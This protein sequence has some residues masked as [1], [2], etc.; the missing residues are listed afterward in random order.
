MKKILTVMTPTY[1]RGDKLKQLYGSLLSQKSNNFKW[2]IVDDG[3]VDETQKIVQGFI[4]DQNKK[5]DISYFYTTNGGKHRAVNFILPKIDTDLL[6]VVDSDDWLKE[7]SV[8]L[9]EKY[10]NKYEGKPELGSLVFE[11]GK[12]NENPIVKIGSGEFIVSRQEYII[13][14]KKFGDYS[15]V[16]ITK[17]INKFRFPEFEN[18]KFI[19]EGPL[20]YEFSKQYKSV[21]INKI[22]K[23]GYYQNDGLTSN[24]RKLQINNSQGS[25]FETRLYLSKDNPLYF[26][27]KKSILFSYIIVATKQNTLKKILYSK[28]VLLII[29]TLP[30]ASLLY[31][32][33]RIKN[34]V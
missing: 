19:S 4:D 18:E 9:V 23:V 16:F 8:Y 31:F 33:D 10:W 5:F 17:A 12:D 2:I 6:L 1:N 22:L 3:S 21:F 27:I 7:N 14:E 30:L 11:R 32:I 20:Y 25:L 15:D 26:R 34:N 13:K 28:H 24:I 29:L